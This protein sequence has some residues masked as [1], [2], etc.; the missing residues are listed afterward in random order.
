MHRLKT[1]QAGLLTWVH[2]ERAP[3]QS[4]LQWVCRPLNPPYSVG[5]VAEFHRL[6]D[7]SHSGLSL[8][9]TPEDVIVTGKLSAGGDGNLAKKSLQA[10][11]FCELTPS[12]IDKAS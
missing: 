6:P 12:C 4:S 5:H 3:S 1:L 8:S 2:L 9:G 10:N 7:Y 11:L